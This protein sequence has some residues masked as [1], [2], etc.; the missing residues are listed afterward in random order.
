VS[1]LTNLKP[2]ELIR[3]LEKLGFE[4]TK[5]SKGGHLR[6]VHPD[7]RK[8]TVPFH[9]GRTIPKGLLEKIIKIDLE[10]NVKDFVKFLK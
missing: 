8:T 9:S 4:R 1:R 5:K 10:T 2:R 3:A 6:Y 7:G